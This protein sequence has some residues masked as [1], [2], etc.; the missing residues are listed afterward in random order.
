M[1]KKVLIIGS[2]IGGSGI[3]ALLSNTNEFE[4]EIF[5]QN[6]L[7][8]G[9]YSTYEKD[10][11][12]LDIGCH[13][14]ANCENGTIGQIFKKIGRPDAVKWSYS[15]NPTPKFFYIDH[16]LLF[17]RELTG[18]EI[19][20]EDLKNLLKLMKRLNQFTDNELV[21]LEHQRID[22]RAFLSDYTDNMKVLSLFSFF[23]GL[24]FVIPDFVTP[25]SEWIRCQRDILNYKTSGYPMG[26]TISIPKAFCDY[27]KDKGGKV[28]T[29]KKV[30]KI[31]IENDKAIGIETEDGKIEGDLIISNAGVKA[32][33]LNL[34]GKQF[35]N[36]N[37][38]KKI[39]S[40]D[41]SLA[42][43][44]TKIA[45]DKEIS[46]EKMIMF[47]GQE[48][49]LDEWY[50][51]A[52]EEKNFIEFLEELDYHPVLFIPIVSNLDPSL[53]PEG[54]Q[55]IIAGGGCPT[56]SQGFNNDK[57]KKKME[58]AIINSLERIYPDIREHI[59]WTETTTPEDINNLFYK[60]GTVVGIGQTV[61]QI[62]I[63][64]PSHELPPL[65]NVYCC[66]ADTGTTGIGGELAANSALE[67]FSKIIK[68]SLKS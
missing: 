52:F 68:N 10:G 51:K 22:M 15:R 18:L 7:I 26:G 61:N 57:Y 25:A 8:G 38:V 64:R 60:D 37:F 12:K 36:E 13:L 40:Y 39:K 17:P 20:A 35:F 56:P 46:S 42:T 50:V 33:V 16:F 59:L 45:L 28:H 47:V 5:E 53:A 58:E 62:G 19:T 44:Q 41:Y 24:Y 29:N 65:E 32:T 4:V 21:E 31:I 3:G 30:K 14:V 1:K 27:V 66:C 49:A 63:N 34:I 43:I 11:W 55:L 2:G 23:A 67:L 9:R 6:S 48:I 54:K